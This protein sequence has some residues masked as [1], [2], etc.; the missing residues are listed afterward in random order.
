MGP[1]D[2]ARLAQIGVQ[3]VGHTACK[4]CVRLNEIRTRVYPRW[5]ACRWRKALLNELSKHRWSP[6]LTVDLLS[7]SV[8][9]HA[10]DARSKHETTR[11]NTSQE[12]HI[13]QM[14][15]ESRSSTIGS[16]RV[17]KPVRLP[18]AIGSIRSLLMSLS[19]DCTAPTAR[20]FKPRVLLDQPFRSHLHHGLVLAPFFFRR[21]CRDGC[22]A[23]RAGMH[24]DGSRTR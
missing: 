6:D 22:R 7:R 8:V 2:G 11:F 12:L 15:D 9:A 10:P 3:H 14:A 4:P 19:M 5:T 24:R 21:E 13:L 1:S 23:V 20:E 17:P 16:S 18:L